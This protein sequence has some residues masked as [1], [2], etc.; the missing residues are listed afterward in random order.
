MQEGTVKVH[1]R[2]IMR[3]L[4]AANRT[5]VAILSQATGLADSYA[6]RN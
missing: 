1:V 4:G 6:N 5:Q 2:F 3:K